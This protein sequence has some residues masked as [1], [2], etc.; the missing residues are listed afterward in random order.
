VTPVTILLKQIELSQVLKTVLEARE[1]ARS[2]TD[3]RQTE[4]GRLNLKVKMSMVTTLL[5]TPKLLLVTESHPRVTT[6][7]TP[8][9]TSPLELKVKVTPQLV[10]R[11]IFPRLAS[12]ELR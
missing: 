2:L 7:R 5:T 10:S 3:L 12:I 4:T 11:K 8:V 6:P 1:E 9:A